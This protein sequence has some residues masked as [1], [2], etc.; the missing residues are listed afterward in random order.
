MTFFKMVVFSANS[1]LHTLMYLAEIITRILPFIKKGDDIFR[2][3]AIK[4]YHNDAL[5][6]V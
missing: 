2:H 1:C 5:E 6:D 3:R 4:R